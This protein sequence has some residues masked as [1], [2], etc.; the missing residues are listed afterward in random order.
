MWSVPL[1]SAAMSA[2]GGMVKAASTLFKRA[3]AL[4]AEKKGERYQPDMAFI[5]C[6]LSFPLLHSCIMCFRGSRRLSGPSVATV[7][8]SS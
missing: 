2:Y 4:I 5:R 1:C 3:A 6:K 8:F 7:A